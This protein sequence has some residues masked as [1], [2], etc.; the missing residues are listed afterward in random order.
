MP[1]D[2]EFRR[3]NQSVI[4]EF[5]ANR[6]V[7]SQPAF[8]VLLLTTTGARTGRRTT[9]PVAYGVDDGRVFVVGSKAG[10]PTHPAWYHNLVARPEVVVEIGDRT[11][12]GH[13]VE[14][15]GDER[16]RLYALISQRVPAFKEYE[17]TSTRV[18]PVIVLDGVPAPARAG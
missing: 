12:T 6:G 17:A 1:S 8:A 5:R 3:W 7:V 15:Q 2:E 13:A 9:T 16:D 18:F 4:A 11:V 10:A 14:I